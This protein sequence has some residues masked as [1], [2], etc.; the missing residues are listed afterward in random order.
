MAL[1]S[2]NGMEWW[3]VPRS[4]GFTTNISIIRWY[5]D[6]AVQAVDRKWSKQ[7]P[8]CCMVMN[9]LVWRL[10]QTHPGPIQI[11]FFDLMVLPRV[12]GNSATPVM[13]TPIWLIHVSAW[14]N[15]ACVKINYVLGDPGRS[16]VSH[17]PGP[18]LAEEQQEKNIM[19]SNGSWKVNIY[20]HISTLTIIKTYDSS[21]LTILNQ[22]MESN[23]GTIMG[24]SVN[25]HHPNR[26]VGWL[27]I[28]WIGLPTL[29]KQ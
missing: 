19:R 24:S 18:T 20:Q 12:V 15:T 7:V 3:L 23:H 16:H 29:H 22:D 6:R 8:S 17:D 1:Q 5:L 9:H 28:W 11:F 26:L 14:I 21:F 4:D 25:T 2:S 10:G 13:D 27:W